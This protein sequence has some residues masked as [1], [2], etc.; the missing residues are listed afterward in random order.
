MRCSTCSARHTQSLCMWVERYSLR[1]Y[2]DVKDAIE[3]NIKENFPPPTRGWSPAGPWWTDAWRGSPAYAGMVPY[4]ASPCGSKEMV[5]PP[6]RGWS[7]PICQVAVDIVVS[8]S[9]RK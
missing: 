6:T 2:D 9:L 5:P 7:L 8:D 4:S 3:R 1:D